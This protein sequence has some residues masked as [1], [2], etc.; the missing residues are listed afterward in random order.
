[1]QN[2]NSIGAYIR[3]KIPPATLYHTLDSDIW[4]NGLSH[5]KCLRRVWIIRKL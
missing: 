1:M 5:W 3:T 2:P 4:Y